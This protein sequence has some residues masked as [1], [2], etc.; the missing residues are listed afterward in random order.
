[1][2]KSLLL[3][4][5][6]VMLTG[7]HRSLEVAG[8]HF[9][10]EDSISPLGVSSTVY[11]KC[12]LGSSDFDGKKCTNGETFVVHSTGAFAS[13]F[14]PVLQAGAIA[15]AGHEVGRGLSKQGDVYNQSNNLSAQQDNFTIRGHRRW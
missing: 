11:G 6:L 9:D 3:V 12:K 15:Y 14:G 7:C 5:L 4:G 1:M 2:K 8:H 10:F 13:L